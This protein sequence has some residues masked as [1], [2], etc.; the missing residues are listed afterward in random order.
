MTVTW[1]FIHMFFAFLAYSPLIFAFLLALLFL[2]NHWFPKPKSKIVLLNTKRKMKF[3]VDFS[4][5]LIKFA[6]PF[7]TLFIITGT[8]WAQKDWYNYW[9]EIGSFFTWFIYAGLFFIHL[10][11]DWHNK[12]SAIFVVISFIA[13]LFTFIGSN[14]FV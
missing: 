13:A 14:F 10:F 12:S 2:I 4:Y 8:I 3:F 7:L 9:F 1:L 5:K 11:K 6:M